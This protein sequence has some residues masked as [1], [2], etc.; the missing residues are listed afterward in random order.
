MNIIISDWVK[1]I[2]KKIKEQEKE[3][4]PQLRK[5]TKKYGYDKRVKEIIYDYLDKNLIKDFDGS[6][7]IILASEVTGEV[8]KIKVLYADEDR[9]ICEENEEIR[10]FVHFMTYIAIEFEDDR[11][12]KISTVRIDT[13]LGYQKRYA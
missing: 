9:L 8:V 13:K 5:Y 7:E 6:D 4:G 2:Q 12:K 3:L 10:R 11:Q 1:S